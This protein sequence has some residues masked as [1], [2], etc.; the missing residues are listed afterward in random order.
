MLIDK[1]YGTCQALLD[2]HYP[3]LNI[4]YIIEFNTRLRTTA[5]RAWNSVPKYRIELNARFLDELGFDAMKQTLVHELAHV[6]C[7]AL[8][9]RENIQPH[10]AEWQR[11]MRTFGYEP[12]RTHNLFEAHAME[13]P[14]GQQ[15]RWEYTCDC[16][17]PH[18]IPTVTHNRIQNG[19]R[20]YQCNECHGGLKFTGKEVI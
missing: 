10:G 1:C 20:I 12:N 18:H 15:R 16:D 17:E 6:V 11:V 13:R 2:R 4:Q 19:T 14:K 5:G 7:Y 8:H 3:H 9:G